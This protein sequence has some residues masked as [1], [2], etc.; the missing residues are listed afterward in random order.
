MNQKDFTISLLEREVERLPPRPLLEG[1]VEKL[2]SAMRFRPR[3]GKK[4]ITTGF[5]KENSGAPLKKKLGKKALISYNLISIIYH[6][7]I[8]STIM[9]ERFPNTKGLGKKYY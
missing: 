4:W 1:E 3:F 2:P 7:I 9:G 8:K 5:V 6:S